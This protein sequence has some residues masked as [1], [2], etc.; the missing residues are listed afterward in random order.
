[1]RGRTKDDKR[2]GAEPEPK[3]SLS[4]LHPSAQ[5]FKY[6]P[7]TGLRYFESVSTGAVIFFFRCLKHY[8][9]LVSNHVEYA[10]FYL[11]VHPGSRFFVR[12]DALY[13]Q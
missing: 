8:R 1:M 11:R 5:A 13:I 9:T 7:L 10:S 3:D 2:I 12:S 6:P 4:A